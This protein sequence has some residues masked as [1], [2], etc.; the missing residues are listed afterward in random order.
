MEQLD[1]SDEAGWKKRHEVQSF[2]YKPS[3]E[4]TWRGIQISISEGFMTRKQGWEVLQRLESI[5]VEERG[6]PDPPLIDNS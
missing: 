1:L 2:A 4:L 3:M 6:S 5:D